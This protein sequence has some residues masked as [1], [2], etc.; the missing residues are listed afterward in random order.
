[1]RILVESVEGK[2]EF[3]PVALGGISIL[4][5]LIVGYWLGAGVGAGVAALGALAL[6]GVRFPN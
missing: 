5:G 6:A 4:V 1:M 3:H 2:R